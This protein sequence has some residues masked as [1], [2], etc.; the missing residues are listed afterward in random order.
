M[1]HSPRQMYLLYNNAV[2]MFGKM[3][4]PGVLFVVLCF[5]ACYIS[6]ILLTMTMDTK[7]EEID[8]SIRRSCP[9]DIQTNAK[10]EVNE[11]IHEHP[12]DRPDIVARVF[13]LK[14][15]ELMRLIN[16]EGILGEIIGHCH[17]YEWQKRSLPHIHLLTVMSK[18]W[19]ITDAADIDD[20]VWA[21][22]PDPGIFI[23]FRV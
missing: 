6:E 20:I 8:D 16:K 9:I 14:K 3:G 13:E 18:E 19:R 15:N 12:H 21:H 5:Y 4:K 7:C 22:I 10:G 17:T 1:K 11:I 2:C 23:T